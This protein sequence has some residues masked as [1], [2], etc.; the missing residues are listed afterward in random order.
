M[1]NPRFASR[2]P[3]GPYLSGKKA[4][5]LEGTD[6]V[7]LDRHLGAVGPLDERQQNA[8]LDP[9][10]NRCDHGLVLDRAGDARAGVEAPQ[11]LAGRV[12]E[13]LEIAFRRSIDHEAAAVSTRLVSAGIPRGNDGGNREFALSRTFQRRPRHREELM[14]D[15]LEAALLDEIDCFLRRAQEM[16]VIR[17]RAVDG[18]VNPDQPILPHMSAHGL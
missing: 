15:N 8:T 1:I 14:V 13:S 4:C 7:P 6:V 5:L 2:D 18:Y 17:G 16:D 12:V 11:L 9:A 3:Q 10:P